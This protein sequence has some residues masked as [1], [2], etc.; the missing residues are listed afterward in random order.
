[1]HKVDMRS[2]SV[3]LA[4]LRCTA[5]PRAD[6]QSVRPLVGEVASN[7]NPL[8]IQV[9]YCPVMAG[10]QYGVNQLGPHRVNG[11]QSHEQWLLLWTATQFAFM[12]RSEFRWQVN[13]R[14]NRIQGL[15]H[16]DLNCLGS[17]GRAANRNPCTNRSLNTGRLFI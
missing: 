2:S 12:L 15:A 16:F 4:L 8:A 17:A 11:Q 7:T 6:E 5:P 3:L 10:L 14:E 9:R 1:M 13:E